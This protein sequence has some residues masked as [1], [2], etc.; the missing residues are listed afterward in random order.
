MD[1]HYL[2]ELLK[3]YY[4]TTLT[5][6]R[7]GV[8]RYTQTEESRCDKVYTDKEESRCDKVY[9]DREESRCD[10]VYTDRGEQV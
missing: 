6:R 5:K 2:E 7:A 10:K 9:T 3:H 1:V 4:G 8:T